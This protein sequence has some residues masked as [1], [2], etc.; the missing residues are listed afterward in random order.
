MTNTGFIG[1]VAMMIELFSANEK[2]PD[3]DHN[4]APN[5]MHLLGFLTHH[6]S[7]TKSS[8]QFLRAKQI[9]NDL[10][11]K[12]RFSSSDAPKNQP[13]PYSKNETRRKKILHNH[14]TILTVYLPL[15]SPT[16]NNSILSF[17]QHQKK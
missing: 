11:L 4:L 14:W 2:N 5:P 16:Q 3:P 6:E 17:Y 12:F 7:G 10:P 13:Q 1:I 15:N 9:P 8:V